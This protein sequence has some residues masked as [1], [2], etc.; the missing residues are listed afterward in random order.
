MGHHGVRNW[1][2]HGHALNR[3]KDSETRMRIRAFQVAAVMPVFVGVCD[4]DISCH[5]TDIVHACSQ[6]GILTYHVAIS[7][8]G[9]QGGIENDRAA[10]GKSE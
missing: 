5:C 7:G 6:P 10:S 1:Q 4:F 9:G 3:A 2:A 8:G